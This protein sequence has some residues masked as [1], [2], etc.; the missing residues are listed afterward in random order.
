MKNYLC[1]VAIVYIVCACSTP[2]EKVTHGKPK[3]PK[4]DTIQRKPKAENFDDDLIKI[5]NTRLSKEDILA[6]IEKANTIERNINAKPPF[7][8]LKYNKVIAYEYSNSFNSIIEEGNFSKGIASQKELTQN[9]INEL[10]DYLGDSS[11]YGGATAACFMPHLG[12]VFY[13]NTTVVAHIS[14]CL[15]CNYL[16]SSIFIESCCLKLDSRGIALKG[17][18]KIGRRKLNTLCQQLYKHWIIRK[19]MFD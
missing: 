9:Q 19:S 12:I 2:K 18:S 3:L 13:Q 5:P 6:F 4:K 1:I 17:F 14:I 15:D 16:N 11:T 7:N 8:T 10:T